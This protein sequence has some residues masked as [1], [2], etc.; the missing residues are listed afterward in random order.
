MDWISV[1]AILLSLLFIAFFSGIEIAFASANTLSIELEKKQGRHSGRTWSRFVNHPALFV[2]TLTVSTAIVMIAYSLLVGDLLFPIWRW[3]ESR[4]P[5]S[6]SDYVK[7]IRLL[8]ETVLATAILLPVRFAGRAYFKARSQSLLRAG[9]V[10]RLTSFFYNLFVSFAASF[11]H[12]AEWI[13]KY[14]FNVK[15]SAKKE[16]FARI[17]VEHILQPSKHAD[18][19]TG[20]EL[21]KE[22]FENALSISDVKLRDCLVP[23][24]EIEAVEMNTGMEAVRKRFI[25][26]RL[27]RLIVFDHDIDNITGYIHQLDLLKNPKS[28]GEAIHPIP[29]V[30]ASMSATDLMNKFSRERKTIAWVVDEFGGTAGLVTIEDLLEKLFGEIKDEYDEV[31]E[32]VDRQIAANEFIFSGRIEL[33][34]ISEKYGLGFTRNKGTETLSGYLIRMNEAIPQEKDRI[35]VDQY[36]F[37]I[38]SVSNT[39]IETVKLKVLS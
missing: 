13:L 24:K 25:D 27:S 18:E 10:S 12:I 2:A 19:E 1:L 11:I 23:R 15:L 20:S 39:R 33:S 5:L 29:M 16:M 7:F 36:E 28:V 8:V 21:N 30:P 35:I 22:L 34:T 3:I 17:D 38:L 37:D 6:A 32:F 14:I 9:W 26:T 31:E 4:L